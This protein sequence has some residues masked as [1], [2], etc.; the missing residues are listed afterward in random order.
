MNDRTH[1]LRNRNR[2]PVLGVRFG[3]NQTRY[4]SERNQGTM[5]IPRNFYHLFGGRI[6]I[7]NRG[8]FK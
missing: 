5:G 1:W 7:I 4:F 2:G 8:I 3:R 6:T